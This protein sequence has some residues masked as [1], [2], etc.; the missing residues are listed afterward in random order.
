MSDQV[1]LKAQDGHELAA[2]VARPD[3]EPRGAVVVIQEIFGINPHMR[4]VADGFAQQGYTAIAPSLFDRFERGVELKYEGEDMQKAFALMQKLDPQTALLDV[5][6]AFEFLKGEQA[7]GIGVVGFCYGGFMTWLAATRGEKVGM[8]PN[9]CIAY[10]PGGIGTVAKE[11][12]S[13]P[14]MVH[15]GQADTHI[16]K[17]QIDAVREAHPEVQMF[18][19]EG[20]GHGFNRVHE[21]SYHEAAA[22]LAQQRTLDFLKSNIVLATFVPTN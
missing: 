1:K 10:Y 15:I 9:C 2:Y 21:A 8:K 3:G 18:T 22:K 20:A 17:D 7:K 6:A 13:F 11:Q 14:V 16:G 12:P 4:S 5:A 19:Y